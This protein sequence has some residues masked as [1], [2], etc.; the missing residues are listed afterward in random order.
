D[1]AMTSTD[2]PLHRSTVTIPRDDNNN[3][4]ADAADQN[5][6]PGTNNAPGDDKDNF[7][8]GPILSL[9]GDRLSRYEEYRGF[10]V[11][12]THMRT[13]TEE[14]DVFYRDASNGQ[15]DG[16]LPQEDWTSENLFGV[17]AEG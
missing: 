17:Y 13:F 14:R 8:V 2:N 1:P 5:T 11:S 16:I 15:E 10:L 7:P 9:R 3:H 4:V 6:G 12:G